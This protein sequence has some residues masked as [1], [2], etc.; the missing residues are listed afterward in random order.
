MDELGEEYLKSLS[1]AN[2]QH[3]EWFLEMCKKDT[4]FC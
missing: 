1:P 4:D 3:T 2:R